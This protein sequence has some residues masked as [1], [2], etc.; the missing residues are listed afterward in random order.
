MNKIHNS[1]KFS[2]SWRGMIVVQINL[3]EFLG[4]ARSLPYRLSLFDT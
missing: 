4:A 1:K 3:N 2:Y